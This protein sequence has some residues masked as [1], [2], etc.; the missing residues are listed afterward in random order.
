MNTGHPRPR[1]RDGV[2]MERAVRE[3]GSNP[4]SDPQHLCNL[5]CVRELSWTLGTKRGRQSPNQGTEG[6]LDKIMNVRS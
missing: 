1:G 2:E 4:T 3:S 6:R 5:G